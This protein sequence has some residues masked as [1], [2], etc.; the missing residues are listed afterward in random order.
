M[1]AEEIKINRIEV[2]N[3]IEMGFEAFC[4]DQSIMRDLKNLREDIENDFF[5]IV[6]LGEFKRG[7]STFINALIKEELLPADVT[8]TTATINA[9]MFDKDRKA[10]V[11]DK[12]GSIEQG[13]ASASFLNK[14]IASN[15]FDPNKIKYLKIGLPSPLLE[16]NVILVDTPGVSD[17]NEQRTQV[18]YDFIPRADVVVFLLD[19][20]SPVKRT[21]KEFIEEHFI[22]I[23]IENILFIANKTDYLDAEDVEEAVEDIKLRLTK[24]FK[25]NSSLKQVKVMPLSASIALKGALQADDELQKE[26]GILDIYKE[27]QDI[28]SMGTKTEQRQKRYAS[29][30]NLILESIE[31]E[32][33]NK[34]SIHQLDQSKL[35]EMLNNIQAL[36]QKEELRKQNL[37]DYIVRQKEDILMMTQKSLFYFRDNLRD[38]MIDMIEAYKGIDF[39]DYIQVQMSSMIK[40][41]MQRWVST[42]ALSIEKVLGQLS[43]EI[44]NGLSSYFRQKVA[45]NNSYEVEESSSMILK[46]PIVIKAQDISNVTTQAG[47]ISA[48]MAGIIALIGGPIIL[49]FISMAAFP[50]LQKKMLEGKLREAK[51]NVKPELNEAINQ[52]VQTLYTEISTNISYRIESIERASERRYEELLNL[53]KQKIQIE[54]ENRLQDKVRVENQMGELQDKLNLL[55]EIKVAL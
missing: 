49:P 55:K 35:N 7:K 5:T 1:K 53:C 42:Y 40:R 46:N 44:A 22:R 4:E 50:M 26:S 19:S 21:E 2:L 41:N 36:I 43:K 3:K 20:T 8:P 18:T 29:K 33:I 45:L 15:D 37:A 11:V 10:Y 39:K 32:L 17:I 16:P 51:I 23:G 14:Y 12:D 48:S 9:L 25:N 13:E 6:V 24:C 47:L 52:S 34:Y 38:E 30:L 28:I 27:I 54:I 31:N